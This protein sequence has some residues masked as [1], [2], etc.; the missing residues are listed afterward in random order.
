M[1]DELPKVSEQLK[2]LI[3]QG[4]FDEV[5]RTL[6]T[7]D[8]QRVADWYAKKSKP[9]MARGKKGPQDETLQ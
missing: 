7:S 1:G 2:K 8:L 9:G 5:A 6:T 3:D 4:R